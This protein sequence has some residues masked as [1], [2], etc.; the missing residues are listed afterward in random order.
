MMQKMKIGVIL[1]LLL[2][3]MTACTDSEGENREWQL[4]WQDEFTGTAGT[5]PDSA[6]W[7]YD[8]GTGW[9]NQQ[10]EYD[11]DRPENVSLDGNG[12]L[13]IVAR[14]ESYMGS[15]YTAARIVTRGLFEP[16]YGRFEARIKL[17]WG[18][19]LW[20]AFWLLGANID[21]VSW[22]QC[23]E[24]DIMEYRGQEVTVV[25]GTIHG[26]GYSASNGISK[27][28]TLP[29]G[30]FDA[31]FHIFAVEWGPDYIDWY[32]DDI[33]YHSVSPEE[34]PGEWVFDHPY[35]IILNLAVGGG[36]VGSP[37]ES[38]VFPQTMAVDYVRVYEEK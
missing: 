20:P 13:L 15:A 9:G 14:K 17:P 16:T 26:P 30:R 24:I 4:V 36:Y 27:S 5:S 19:G 21:E 31:N 6:K 23:G 2:A 25:H 3:L 37:N 12:N 29:D 32:V 1:T 33:H 8:I 38:T 7:T 11:T 35:Y 28:Y 34:L 10:L 18:Q 22:P